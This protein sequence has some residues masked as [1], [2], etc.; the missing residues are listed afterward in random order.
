MSASP[1]FMFPSSFLA[2]SHCTSTTTQ[3]ANFRQS[4]LYVAT[5][6][7]S[8]STHRLI[9]IS[10]SGSSAFTGASPRLIRGIFQKERDEGRWQP[11]TNLLFLPAASLVS[12][13]MA[14]ITAPTKPRPITT[15]IS[16]FA[17]RACCTSSSM[18]FNSLL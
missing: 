14:A 11:I 10:T 3:S 1:L 9:R 13:T 12:A 7:L 6:V 8:S 2:K 15:T 4:L 17:L 5:R 18:R 16:L